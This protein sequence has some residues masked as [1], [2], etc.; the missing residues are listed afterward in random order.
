MR[1]KLFFILATLAFASCQKE[2]P[3][4]KTMQGN[5]SCKKNLALTELDN[6]ESDYDSIIP[7]TPDTNST[8]Y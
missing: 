3:L 7:V 6:F 5:D 2:I 4:N 1:K 8:M